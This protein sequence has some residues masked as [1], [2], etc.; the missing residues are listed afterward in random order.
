LRR[1]HVVMNFVLEG[2]TGADKTFDWLEYFDCVLTGC[3]KPAFFT[4]RRPLFEVHTDTGMLM[5]TDNGSPMALVWDASRPDSSASDSTSTTSSSSRNGGVGKGSSNGGG[6]R[7][8]GGP[9]PDYSRGEPAVSGV[10]SSSSP[11]TSTSTPT[12]AGIG[13]SGGGG[14]N[15]RKR[16]RVFQGGYYT[17]LHRMLDVA[18]GAEVLYVSELFCLFTSF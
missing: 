1:S 15:G 3:G 2:R 16:A 10:P 17:D 18:S 14:G 4:E 7:G 6:G 12:A 11:S 8:T 13:G 5:N 9:L